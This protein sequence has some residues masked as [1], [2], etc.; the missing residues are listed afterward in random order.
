LGL[1]GLVVVVVVVSLLKRELFFF[2]KTI[3]WYACFNTRINL[4]MPVEFL[5]NNKAVLDISKLG[6]ARDK[7][8]KTQSTKVK[9][10]RGRWTWREKREEM[11]KNSE[12]G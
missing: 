3:T 6:Q 2:K 8:Q 10:K 9:N 11:K 5:D 4:V 1:K 12:G 7:T